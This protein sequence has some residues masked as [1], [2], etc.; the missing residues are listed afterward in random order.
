MKIKRLLIAILAVC[1]LASAPSANA[2]YYY[3]KQVHPNEISASYG[4]SLLGSVFSGVADKFNFI[5]W[6]VEDADDYVVAAVGGSK[7]VI[8]LGYSYQL[9]KTISVGAAA[10]FNKMS[11]D[12]KDKQDHI[13]AFSA[14]VMFLMA[15]GKFDWF[16]TGN[17][18]F[19]MYSKA[20]VG[21]MCLGA[22][23]M[24]EEHLSGNI[25]FPTMQL[26]AVGLELGRAFS[27]FMEFGLGMQGIV[28][29]GI[30]GRF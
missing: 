13:H 18:I 27:G 12:L 9:N 11:L 14:N 28:Q 23:V 7:G 17:D 6:L 1:C 16:R 30:R 8:N 19:G 10:G 25:W 5:S 24:E 4:V 29:F 21:V 2:Q 3:Y 15:T 26:T 20:G 22:Q